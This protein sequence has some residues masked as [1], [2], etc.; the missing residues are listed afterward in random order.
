LHTSTAYGRI[1]IRL[2]GDHQPR[3]QNI[4]IGDLA[5]FQHVTSAGWSRA[6]PD[7]RSMT[8]SRRLLLPKR[9]SK[10]PGFEDG[11]GTAARGELE[12]LT[13]TVRAAGSSSA[14][15]RSISSMIA[16]TRA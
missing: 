12:K 7:V 11:D 6:G 5:Q 15:T 14:H 3:S 9:S 13:C 8:A 1:P 4:A 2:A 10:W 16:L